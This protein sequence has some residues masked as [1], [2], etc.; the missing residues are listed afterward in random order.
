[1]VTPDQYRMIEP[2]YGGIAVEES[3]LY[4]FSVYVKVEVVGPR[5][6]LYL[7]WF[8]QGGMPTD[9]MLFNE[10]DSE[11]VPN[12]TNWHQHMIQAVAPED[13]IYLVPGIY[14]TNRSGGPAGRSNY[15]EIAAVQVSQVG[16]EKVVTLIPPNVF[17]TMGESATGVGEAIGP[18]PR[19]IG[20]TPNVSTLAAVPTANLKNGDAYTLTDPT[21]DEVWA[22]NG[23]AWKKVTETYLL[24]RPETS[25]S[26]PGSQT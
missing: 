2:R 15:V 7:L 8:R 19:L 6:K 26:T 21:P 17:L 4:L 10:S 9:L 5:F 18:A 11:I 25:S 23:N 3:M 13:A 24:G 22:W 20:S 1:M 16:N 12:D 14:F